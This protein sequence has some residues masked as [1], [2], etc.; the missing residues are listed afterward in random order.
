MEDLYRLGRTTVSCEGYSFSG[1]SNVLRGSCGVKY[2]LHLTEKGKDRHI[3]GKRAHSV[4]PCPPDPHSPPEY[5]GPKVQRGRPQGSPGKRGPPGVT[6]SAPQ[7][8]TYTHPRAQKV[9]EEYDATM[10]TM[11]GTVFGVV[12]GVFVITTCID[13]CRSGARHISTDAV[14]GAAVGAVAATVVT[15]IVNP[16]Q[17]RPRRRNSYQ[18]WDSGSWWGGSGS[19]GPSYSS[20]SSN[21][22]PS[23][24]SYSSSS[25]SN[26][27][28]N[29]SSGSNSTSTSTGYGGSESR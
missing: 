24:S 19:S 14:V 13:C 20:Y 6:R 3:R 17:R 9:P 4:L 23:Y 8:Y 15:N 12:V 1:D 29:S 22:G 25:S 27:S 21:S 11:L 18:G 10:M 26:N 16:V 5:Q 7:G 2:T 28:N